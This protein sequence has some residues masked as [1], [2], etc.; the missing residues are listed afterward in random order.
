MSLSSHLHDLL[1]SQHKQY[2]TDF[3][4]TRACNYNNLTEKDNFIA[5]EYMACVLSKHT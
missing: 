4:M 5:F 1:M 2:K 3:D